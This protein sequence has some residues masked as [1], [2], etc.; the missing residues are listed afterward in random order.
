M[1]SPGFQQCPNILYLERSVFP[2]LLPGLDAMLRE[3]LKHQCLK[4]E[5][6]TFNGCD[7]LTEWLYNK[8]EKRAGNNILD[9]QKIPFVRDWLSKHPRPAVPITL[10]LT[11]EQAAL[12][13]QAFWRGYKIR[14]RPDVQELRQWQK[15][16]REENRDV[17]KAV[18]ESRVGSEL[19]DF[20]DEFDQ[21]GESGVSIQVVSPTPYNTP[22]PH[23][24]L[25]GTI[26]PGLLMLEPH[27]NSPS[28]T[29]S[30]FQGP[31]TSDRHHTE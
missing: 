27:V 31:Q 10:Q 2:V 12:L 19:N 6:T 22:A 18:Q 20:V 1:S 5:G 26:T 23:S 28:Q 15:K 9:F 11:D 29:H 30:L 16:L 8:N 24:A 13:I 14:T 17:V 25:D 3:A 4:K 7:F 21:H